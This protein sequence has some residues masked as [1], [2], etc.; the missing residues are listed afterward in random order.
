MRWNPISEQ[1]TKELLKLLGSRKFLALI[2]EGSW[3]LDFQAMGVGAPSPSQ[4][5]GPYFEVLVY[6]KDIL[7]QGKMPPKIAVDPTVA[8]GGPPYEDPSVTYQTRPPGIPLGNAHRRLTKLVE[9]I[10][11]MDPTPSGKNTIWIAKMWAKGDIRLEEDSV[12][13]KDLLE[14][15]NTHKRRLA[16]KDINKYTS[17][18]DLSK[19]VRNA[20]PSRR[21]AIKRRKV[22]GKKLI[23][24]DGTIQSFYITSLEAA[25]DTFKDTEWCV[26]GPRQY[27]RYIEGPEPGDPGPGF[28]IYYSRRAGDPILPRGPQEPYALYYRNEEGYVEIRD[29]DNDPIDHT[30]WKVLIEHVKKNTP[31]ALCP[32]GTLPRLVCD[33]CETMVCSEGGR[34]CTD[35]DCDEIVCEGCSGLEICSG[36]DEL[37]CASHIDV[38]NCGSGAYCSECVTECPECND[39]MCGSCSYNC[40][41]CGND[42]CRNCEISCNACGEVSCTSCITRCTTCGEYI[43]RECMEEC[44]GCS[45]NKCQNCLEICMSCGADTCDDCAASC[46]THGCHKHMLCVNCQNECPDCSKIVCKEHFKEDVPLPL[47]GHKGGPD[48]CESCLEV[49]SQGLPDLDNEDTEQR[50]NPA[51]FD[52]EKMEADINAIISGVRHYG[53]KKWKIKNRL[54]ATIL[55]WKNSSARWH[56]A[57]TVETH[58]R[59]KKASEE[60]LRRLGRPSFK[61]SKTHYGWDQETRTFT[62]DA[63]KIVVPYTI[64][65][66]KPLIDQEDG[67]LP[68]LTPLPLYEGSFE[69]K[70]KDLGYDPIKGFTVTSDLEMKAILHIRQ[71]ELEDLREKRDSLPTNEFINYII[72]TYGQ[73]AAFIEDAEPWVREAA[74][75]RIKNWIG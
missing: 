15:F 35:E 49:I 38:C 72:Q 41:D 67:S 39:I 42:V 4:R 62:A 29:I 66:L 58:I 54:R 34:Q 60:Y 69:H 74:V 28:L 12:K 55:L 22:A 16:K 14:R 6:F 33:D 21:K 59:R 40:T 44:P 19:A 71:P 45:E 30:M 17:Y 70:T 23:H 9:E 46:S 32:H 63:D 5:L 26:R 64:K 68:S 25:V 65:E 13:T 75:A 53:S 27:K 24:D 20:D 8:F 57:G 3:G 61:F 73:R 10:A 1:R 51:D 56:V 31:E 36:C 11:K 52:I 37:K 50:L 18:S 47:F 7:R 2:D 43:C 48:V